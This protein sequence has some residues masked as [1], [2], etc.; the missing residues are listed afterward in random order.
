MREVVEFIGGFAAAIDAPVRT[1]TEVTHVRPVDDGYR[2]VTS[3]GR[4]RV[5]QPRHRERRVQRARR[6][7]AAAKP[8][9]H[10]SRASR[11]S[12]TAIRRPCPTAACSSSARR[13]PGVQLAD[14]IRRSG[15]R[16][17]L[18]VGEHVRLPR[19]YRGR[20]VLW[21]MEAC[22]HL[23]PALRRDRRRRARAQAAV[24]AARRLAGAHD[25]RLERVERGG[26]RDRRTGSPRCATGARCSRA[27]CAISS[28]S[29][30]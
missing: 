22:G 19:T 4:A 12:T 29:R 25:A 24:A 21:W 9:P 15:R 28:R 23:E 2:V 5:P 7:R 17:L 1:H 27:V 10:R 26:R 14:E 8:C 16:V 18:S 11:R 6:A 30:I 13:P 20:D 3:Q